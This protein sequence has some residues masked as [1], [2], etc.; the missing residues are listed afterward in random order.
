MVISNK[1]TCKSF[2][3]VKATLATFLTEIIGTFFSVNVQENLLVCQKTETN[4]K[5]HLGE[6]FN[7]F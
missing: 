7:K 2:D 4:L 1:I 5:V 6:W 3:L